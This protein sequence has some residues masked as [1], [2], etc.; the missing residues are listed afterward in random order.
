MQEQ[1]VPPVLEIDAR[2]YCPDTVHIGAQDATGRMIATARLLCE[3]VSD[4]G[5]TR[6]HIGRVA[7]RKAWRAKGV[8]RA[9]MRFTFSVAR[10]RVRDGQQLE[11]T[12]DSQMAA[13]G[14]YRNLGYVPTGRGRFWD[15]GILHQEMRAT[16]TGTAPSG[17]INEDGRAH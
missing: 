5:V 3:G 17:P 14:F 4:A 10:R 15:A 8:G 1:K 16:S 12:L 2:D 11:V 6:F 7:V 13:E 9:L